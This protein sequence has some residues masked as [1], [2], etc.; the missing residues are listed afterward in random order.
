MFLKEI[1]RFKTW[2]NL[3]LSKIYS[4]GIVK[5]HQVALCDTERDLEQGTLEEN[6]TNSGSLLESYVQN[7]RD[8]FGVENMLYVL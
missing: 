6:F 5:F 7:V 8:S 3:F 2:D 1:L 4:I